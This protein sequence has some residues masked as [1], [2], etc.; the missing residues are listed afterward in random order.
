MWRLSSFPA[1]AGF[2]LAGSVFSAFASAG[3]AAFVSF[4]VSF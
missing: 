3:F 2:S 1:S 4:F